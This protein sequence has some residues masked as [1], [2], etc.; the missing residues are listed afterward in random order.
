MRPTELLRSSTLRLALLYMV[1]FAGSVLMLLGFIYWS[2]VRFMSQQVDTTIETEIVGLAE[3]YRARGLNGLVRTINERMERNPGGSSI[4]LFAAA[5][6]RRLAGNLNVWPGVEADAEGWLDFEVDNPESGLED[7]SARA[8]TFTLQGNFRLLVGRDVRELQAT[9]ALIERALLGGLAFTIALALFVGFTLT[10]T[11]LRRL[12]DIN[13]TS[14]EIMAGDLSRRVVTRGT[15]DEFDQL[16]GNL[17]AMLDEIERLMSGI[18]HMSDNIAHDL[19]TPLTRLRQRLES[20]DEPTLC[21]T[22]RKERIDRSITD[23]DQLLDTFSALLRIAR[24]DAGGYRLQTQQLNAGAMLAD[25]AELYEAIAE[26][27][28]LTL[29][30][31]QP[32]APVFFT[33]DRDLV[34]QALTNLLDNALKYTPAGGHV[35]L[36]TGLANGEAFLSVADSGPGIPEDEREKVTRRFYRVEAS[37]TT[38]GSGLG[39]SLVAAVAAIHQGSLRLEDN[40]PGLKAV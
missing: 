31:H 28:G 36:G 14:R 13:D 20:L 12:E 19:R 21:P 38:A 24:F 1:L 29:A 22:E 32:I 3:Q 15:S 7:V 33:V 2:T 17:N 23:A 8:R 18:R 6:L 27:R 5:D 25:A 4:Y 26:D 11:T 9:T 34:F 39:L 30:V 10:R 16:A 37:R 35:D 40:Q